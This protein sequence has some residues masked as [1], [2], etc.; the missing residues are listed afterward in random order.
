VD[1]SP[2]YESVAK[3]RFAPLGKASVISVVAASLL[4][5]LPVFAIEIP[6]E[7]LLWSLGTT[8]I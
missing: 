3:M 5:L 2:I 6:M 8:L 4:P 7:E 1:I